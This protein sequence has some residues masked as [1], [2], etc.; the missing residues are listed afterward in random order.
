MLKKLLIFLAILAGLAALA[1]R[2]LA[3]VAGN[4]TAA[5]VRRHEGLRE[6][7]DVTFKGFPFLTQAV[8]GEF[9]EVALTVRDLEREGLTVDRIDATLR[10]VEVDMS[11]ALDGRLSAVPIER[12]EATVRV[13]YGD[14]TQY[15]ASKP[16][17]IRVVVRDGRPVVLST[18]GIP[19]VGQVEVVG[20]P[21]VRVQDAEVRV[22]VRDVR[23]AVGVAG[24]LTASLAATAGARMS[25]TI[26]LEEL[27]FGITLKS[28]ELTD[29]A[30]VVA[31]SAEG[32][33]V[34][35]RDATR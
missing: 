17:N 30:L 8:K 15:L 33:V 11:A 27:P 9:R 5:T 2:G 6:D 1:D 4:A 10:G 20:T 34:D 31:A 22:T 14:L 28:A 3:V 16:G 7:P 18:F 19:G 25:F 24:G 32:I 29:D 21:T 13:T 23:L 26:P 12:G 35:V